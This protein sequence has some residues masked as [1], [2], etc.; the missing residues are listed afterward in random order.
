MNGLSRLPATQLADRRTASDHVA[1]ALR[2]AILTGVF[3]DGEELNQVALARHFEISRV[4]I[5]EALR[6]LQAEGLVRQKAH[7]RAVVTTLTNERIDELFDL[8]ST[9]E[10]YMLERAILNIGEADLEELDALVERMETVA[11]HREWL[12]LN[13]QYHT[14]LYEPSRAVYTLE[15]TEQ[16]AARATRYLYLRSG[17]RGVERVKEANAEHVALLDAVKGRDLRRATYLLQTHIEGTRTRV[18]QFLSQRST[19]ESDSP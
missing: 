2:E 17:G 15:L 3:E 10:V 7:K 16:I 13:R 11:D 14:R 6:E 5:R 19:L 1:A 12:R 18:K 4:P 8:R 9:L